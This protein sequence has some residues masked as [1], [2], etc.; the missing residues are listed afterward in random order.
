MNTIWTMSEVINF[1]K[2]A[3]GKLAKQHSKPNYQRKAYYE[4]PNEKN[5]YS[6]T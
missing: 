1:A 4:P 5:Q 6:P 3:E 2:K